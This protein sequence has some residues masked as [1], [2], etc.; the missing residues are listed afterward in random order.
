MNVQIGKA[1]RAVVQSGRGKR[2]RV[3]S[4]RLPAGK[5]ST[6]T[7]LLLSDLDNMVVVLMQPVGWNTCVKLVALHCS[8]GLRIWGGSS[9]YFHRKAVLSTLDRLGKPKT[10]T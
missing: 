6:A 5:L 9:R 2:E 1:G 10:H 3:S 4:A 7:L 8:E